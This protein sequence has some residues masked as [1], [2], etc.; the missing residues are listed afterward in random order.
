MKVT[1]Y[2]EKEKNGETKMGMKK[3][4]EGRRQVTNFRKAVC[5]SSAVVQGAARRKNGWRGVPE[6]TGTPGRSN[7]HFHPTQTG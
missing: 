1:A 5:C 6:V 2:Q 7:S 3:A 4:R